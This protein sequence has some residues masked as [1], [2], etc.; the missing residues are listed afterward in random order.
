[1][2]YNQLNTKSHTKKTRAG[3][4]IAAG[5]GKTAGRGTKGQNAR[6]GGGVRPGF[7]GGQNPLLQRIPK[8]RGFISARKAAE[9][10]YT[11]QLGSLK[12]NVDN[13]TLF[14]AGLVSSPHTKVKLLLKGEVS[15]KF[16]IKLQSASKQAIEVVQKAGGSFTKVDQVKRQAKPKTT[17]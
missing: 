7:E 17:K 3:R 14:D 2:K 1:M 5:R 13:F 4:G 9:V 16:D 6:T 12:S 11:N 15:K 8:L 10:V